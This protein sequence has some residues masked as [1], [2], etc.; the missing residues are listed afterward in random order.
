[1]SDKGEVSNNVEFLFPV[2]FQLQGQ[3]WNLK[4]IRANKLKVR[5]S[6]P[7]FMICLFHVQH[8]P[9]PLVNINFGDIWEK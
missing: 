8:S 3:S 9:G 2:T 6:K 1:M 5:P 7:H 4:L